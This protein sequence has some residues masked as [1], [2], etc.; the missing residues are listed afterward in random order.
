M[1]FNPA[2]A[3]SLAAFCAIVV[4]VSYALLLAVHLSYRSFKVTALAGVLLGIWLGI[5]SAVVASGRMTSLPF[6][7]LPFFFG[8]ILVIW[9]TLALST[10][11]V[12][13]IAI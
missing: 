6:N 8:P 1:N 7:G 5:Q 13:E 4:A 9:T 2:T 11:P 12:A 3:A 10:E